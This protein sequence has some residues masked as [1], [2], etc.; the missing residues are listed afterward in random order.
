[1]KV[2]Y[3]CCVGSWDKLQAY[4]VPK[5]EGRELH[6]V[7]GTT[8]ISVAYNQILDAC[9]GRELDAL[10]LLHDDLEI[11][12]PDAESK[13]LEVLAY[14]QVAVAGVCGGSARNGL[15]WWSAD[16]IGHQLTDTGMIDF[17][18]RRGEVESLE[19]S[20]MAFSPWALR[21]LRFDERFGGFHGYDHIGVRA[22]RQGGRVVVVDVDTHHHTVTGFKSP[23]SEAA[24]HEADRMFRATY[25]EGV[26]L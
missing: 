8:S 9:S 22:R 20:I 23:E 24:W 13:F 15:A 10:I 6:C 21:R 19:G 2:A 11:T 12:D 3:G 4:V 16:P 5:V 17:G 18:A 26:R 14:D 25:G 7:W 1:M